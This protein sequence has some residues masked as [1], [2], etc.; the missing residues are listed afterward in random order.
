MVLMLPALGLA[1][2]ADVDAEPGQFFQAR[3]I[4]GGKA[5]QRRAHWKHGGHG[6]NAILQRRVALAEKLEAVI[7]AH[8]AAIDACKRGIDHRLMVYRGIVPEVVV[9]VTRML[10]SRFRGPGNR[11][12]SR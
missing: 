3:R 12:Q 9:A 6:A 8:F 2:G 4:K 10:V 5:C 7:K 1:V 11:G